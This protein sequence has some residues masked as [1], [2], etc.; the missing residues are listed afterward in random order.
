MSLQYS[1][2][3]RVVQDPESDLWVLYNFATGKSAFLSPISYGLYMSA[4]S[5][6]ESAFTKSLL[7]AGF[8][9][10]CDE[11]EA[12]RHATALACYGSD[13]LM[14]T[15]CPTL[16][17]NFACPYCYEE[18]RGGHMGQDVQDAFVRFV[19]GQLE[20]F[21]LR[22]MCVVWFGGEPLLSPD[23]IDALSVRLI[24]EARTFGVEYH[25]NIV[26]NASLLV[27]EV[28]E[29]LAR[30]QVKGIQV[31]LDGPNPQTND[32]YRKMRSGKGSFETI[33]AN[34]RALP[35]GFDVKIRCNVGPHNIGMLEDMR[36]LVGELDSQGESSFTLV[37]GIM[38][39][40]VAKSTDGAQAP[41]GST[42]DEINRMFSK[43]GFID[44]DAIGAQM[45]GKFHG[46]FC[47]SQRAHTYAIDELGNMYRCWE[48]CGNVEA[49]FDTVM[50]MAENPMPANVGAWSLYLD[51]AW[52]GDD[53][54]CAECPILPMCM[55][56]CPHRYMVS[57]VRRCP[58]FKDDPDAYVLAKT[59]ASRKARQ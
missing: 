27:P 16:A 33:M 15:V 43:L 11:M 9:T 47:G 22:R 35:A 42:F 51:S 24:D 34:L 28:A 58:W 20:R 13:T 36:A 54:Q 29:M 53:P 23:I 3:N 52:C 17:C 5:M 55:G 8:L 37:P 6:P 10:T 59:R 56:G 14:L 38:D 26:T 45:P 19:H 39:M 48:D 40:D 18:R 7:R 25:A 30:Q 49:S 4:L 46:S 50:H 57:G 44:Y 2:F 21:G 1:R 32:P 12:L 31:T 41:V